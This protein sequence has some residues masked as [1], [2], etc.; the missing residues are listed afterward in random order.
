VSDTGPDTERERTT[1]PCPPSD[2]SGEVRARVTV[3]RPSIESTLDALL[4]TLRANGHGLAALAIEIAPF[5]PDA[6]TEASGSLLPIAAQEHQAGRHDR[7][8]AIGWCADAAWKLGFAMRSR[9]REDA[10][11]VDFWTRAASATL[12]GQR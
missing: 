6:L 2:P 7:A 10:P 5:V 9:L 11:S 3:V 8:R 1:S 12:A 4:E